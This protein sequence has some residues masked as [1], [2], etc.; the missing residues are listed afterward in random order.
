MMKRTLGIAAAAA[1]IAPT[2]LLS[3]TAHAAPTTQTPSPTPAPPVHSQ[4]QIAAAAPPPVQHAPPFPANTPAPAPP[5]R[6]TPVHTP[7]APPQVTTQVPPPLVTTHAPVTTQAPPPPVT[8]QP[9]PVTSPPVTTPPKP[10]TTAPVTTAAPTPWVSPHGTAPAGTPAPLD[11]SASTPSPSRVPAGPYE[12]GETPPP[13]HAPVAAP[14]AP[15]VSVPQ[16]RVE[17]AKAAKPNFV[18][19]LAPPPPPP[20]SPEGKQPVPFTQQVN[21]IITTIRVDNV[22][23]HQVV[24]AGHYG[25]VDYDQYH[26]PYFYNPM[27]EPL[28]V[29]YYYG[30]GYRQVFI[31]VGARMVMNAATIGLYPFTVVGQS[32]LMA[33]S[34]LGGAWIPPDG[35][36]GPPPADYIPPAEPASY[37]DVNAYVPAA[38]QSVLVNKVTM[39]GHDDSLP[40]GQQDAFMINDSTLAHGKVDKPE[41]G[42]QVTVATTQTL[43]GVGPTDS[44][45]S[46]LP[47]KQVGSSSSDQLWP[48]ALGG[49]VL[50]GLAGGVAT[51]AIRRHPTEA[52]TEVIHHPYDRGW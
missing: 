3:A 39:I 14:Q 2:I 13:N 40:E 17:E 34:F 31:P 18:D 27:N 21:N 43:P 36:D 6:Q 33:G 48:W 8:T 26:R 12:S 32:L 38:D 51:W 46:I 50:A 11:S 10:I 22:D 47:V 4:P 52:D 28:T 30:G 15:K 20:P 25:F 49:V 23:N 19:P 37:T 16:A 45:Q 5:P 24:R 44:G 41:D 42:G 9:K 35:W 1:A 29:Q 7:Q